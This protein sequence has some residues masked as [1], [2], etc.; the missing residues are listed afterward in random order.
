[1]RRRVYQAQQDRQARLALT[2]ALQPAGERGTPP[3][4]RR[5][6]LS[7]AAVATESSN[8]A[9]TASGDVTSAT[10]D[11]CDGAAESPPSRLAGERLTCVQPG[12]SHWLWGSVCRAPAAGSSWSAMAATIASI[13]CSDE[14]PSALSKNDP[15]LLM[16]RGPDWDREIIALRLGQPGSKKGGSAAQRSLPER[17]GVAADGSRQQLSERGR[18]CAGPTRSGMGRAPRCGTG[19]S[20]V[21]R[22]A[23][24]RDR[25]RG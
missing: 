7:D 10:R 3:A 4:C 5:T 6:K 13:A 23:G 18:G 20:G 22:G 19:D 16:R 2:L 15:P 17:P 24:R 12:E 8:R 9:C 11:P 21:R 25:G 14:S 1:M